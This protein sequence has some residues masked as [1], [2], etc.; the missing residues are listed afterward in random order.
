M[1]DESTGCASQSISLKTFV[2]HTVAGLTWSS[3]EACLVSMFTPL[4]L[5]PPSEIHDTDIAFKFSKL[6]YNDALR[7]EL[8]SQRVSYTNWITKEYLAFSKLV[9]NDALR[10]NF[11]PKEFLTPIELWSCL[12]L[13]TI[14]RQQTY[15][16]HASQPFFS[17]SKTK[18]TRVV[19]K[20]LPVDHASQLIL[21]KT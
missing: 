10:L 8:Y 17:G 9:Y 19:K 5:T 21:L 1:G 18:E 20:A 12:L 14:A 2:R 13:C 7:V 6:F 15:R 11:T 3:R 4:V 16:V